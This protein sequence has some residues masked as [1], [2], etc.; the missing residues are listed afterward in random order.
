MKYNGGKKS[1]ECLAHCRYSHSM[2]VVIILA[3]EAPGGAYPVFSCSKSKLLPAA[4]KAWG[5]VSS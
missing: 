5:N 3:P 1:C 4:L 2:E